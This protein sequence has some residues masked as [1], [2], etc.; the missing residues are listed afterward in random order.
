[1]RSTFPLS[2]SAMKK[3]EL[4]TGRNAVQQP[5]VQRWTVLSAIG[6]NPQ[7]RLRDLFG[8]SASAI[9]DQ[10]FFALG[11]FAINTI[12]ARQMAPATFG[13]FSA[14]FAAFLLL[15][16]V[17]CAFVVD[18]MLIFG[19]SSAIGLQKSYVRRV[20]SLHWRA[21]I[22]LS[23]LL[24]VV[25]VVHRQ[26]G[27][28]EGAVTA[29]LGWAIA[30]PAVLRL[31]LA[32]RTS[33][34]VMKPHYAAV[35]GAVYLVAI[36]VLLL[37]F[38]QYL[39]T[40]TIAACLLVAC[41]SVVVAVFLHR[42]LPLVD[43]VSDS[44]AAN[45]ILGSHWTFGKWAS[46]AG[47]LALFPDY[48]YLFVL[49]PERSAQYRAL[50]NVVLPLIQVYNALGVLMMSYFARSRDRADFARIVL[51][52]TGGF[53][54]VAAL[55][56]VIVGLF[57]GEI[58][59]RLYAGKYDLSLNL[60]WPLVVVTVLFALRTVSDALLRATENVTAMATIAVVAAL[61]AVIIGVP[62]ALRFGV[63]GAVY[64]DLAVYLVATAAIAILWVRLFRRA[65]FASP[66]QG[67]AVDHNA[68]LRPPLSGAEPPLQSFI[69]S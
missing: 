54:A 31:W 26:F 58:F 35:A 39:A 34:L 2:D 63:L 11:N 18:P 53:F 64:G 4:R 20:V 36:A 27:A 44:V 33:Y 49:P 40:N 15:S 62:L 21:A 6:W 23:A 1:M 9:S 38:G 19:V 22:A 28:G 69:E 10:G 68:T 65:P 42:N 57:G 67:F 45:N 3:M 41:T 37:V 29:Y 16:T 12:L 24:L 51:R 61:A 7:W 30:A 56:A 48:V 5:P 17:Y 25:G 66:P 52:I 8:Q 59:S 13:R 47:I 50:L 43:T 32:R 46:F 14:A 55:L 60:L